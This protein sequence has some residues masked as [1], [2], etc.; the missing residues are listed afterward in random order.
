M[1][2]CVTQNSMRTR[3]RQI[4]SAIFFDQQ[5]CLRARLLELDGISDLMGGN[6][7]SWHSQ[8]LPPILIHPHNAK[9]PTS[10]ALS[11]RAPGAARAT[12]GRE[13][14]PKPATGAFSTVSGPD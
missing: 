9:N 6:Q 3:L 8:T 2:G 14:K 4:P 10:G 7:I 5:C 1:P 13:P 11:A 12:P